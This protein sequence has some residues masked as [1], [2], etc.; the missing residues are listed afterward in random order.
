MQIQFWKGA[1]WRSH[2]S[3]GEDLEPLGDVSVKLLREECRCWMKPRPENSSCSSECQ[4][5]H[6]GEAHRAVLWSTLQVSTTRDL[7]FVNPVHPSSSNLITG[8]G[9]GTEIGL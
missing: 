7:L 4:S 5:L 8:T 6:T 9:T 3:L 2:Y 1:Y